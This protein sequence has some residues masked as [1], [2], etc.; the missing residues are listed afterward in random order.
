MSVWPI[1][2]ERS[3]GYNK[4][5]IALALV[6]IYNAYSRKSTPS[7]DHDP[8]AS[9]DKNKK[10]VTPPTP[11]PVRTNW[12]KDGLALGSFIFTLHCFVT[13]PSTIISWTWTGYPLKGPLPHLHGSLTHVAQAVGLLIP[14]LA[15]HRVLSHPGVF[16]YG[17]TSAAG[18]YLYKDWVG[19]FAGWNFAVFLMS[20][21][22]TVLS[23]AA[24]NK[25]IGK[26]YCLAFLTAALYDVGNTFTV[27][28][29]FVPGGEVF[30]ERTN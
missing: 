16:A 14:T 17:A 4:T 6:A 19:Y 8:L 12:L 23:S 26:T 24:M 7:L 1:V 28:Y 15:S 25:H 18:M 11:M 10:D 27:A 22:P 5:G 9:T 13:D 3:G 29:A 2:D 20:V 21:I 30:R